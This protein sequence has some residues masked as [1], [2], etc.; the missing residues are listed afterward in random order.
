MS[1]DSAVVDAPSGWGFGAA[2]AM[3]GESG[4][5]AAGGGASNVLYFVFYLDEVEGV[6]AEDV[7][8]YHGSDFGR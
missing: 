3:V 5:G 4:A 8:P 1:R 6:G 2:V 7:G